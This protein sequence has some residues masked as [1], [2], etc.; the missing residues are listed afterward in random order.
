MRHPETDVSITTVTSM[1]TIP[2]TPKSPANMHIFPQIPYFLCIPRG[3]GRRTGPEYV[4]WK[5]IPLSSR[6]LKLLH[7]R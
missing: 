5:R 2:L 3:G 4:V 1:R 7:F 6:E